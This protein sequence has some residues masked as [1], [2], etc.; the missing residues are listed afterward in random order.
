MEKQGII[1]SLDKFIEQA[2][3]LKTESGPKSNDFVKW[4]REV[5]Q[6]IEKN[7]GSDH[8]Q[9]RAFKKIDYYPKQFDILSSESSFKKAW[10]DGLA[11]AKGILEKLRTES[12]SSSD[13]QE[14]EPV[15]EIK[16][17]EEE[18]I[19]AIK[20]EEPAPPEPKEVK[21]EEI[22]LPEAQAEIEVE[23]QEPEI[24][25]IDSPKENNITA[26]NK[27][28]ARSAEKQEASPRG[29]KVLLVNISDEELNE[30]IFKFIKRMGYEPV[31][32]DQ[33][34]DGDVFSSDVLIS[35]MY[36]NPVF[37]II[38]WRAEMECSGRKLPKPHIIFGTGFYVAKLTHKRVLI[39]SYEDIDFNSEE[40]KG[41]NFLSIDNIQEL[42]ELKL[43][44][45]MDIAG[46]NIDFNFLKKK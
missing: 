3:V 17:A 10:L 39:I 27:K 32:V 2:D 28:E 12:L 18:K 21:V 26:K 33:N 20:K 44:R 37:A 38:H 42:M 31:V 8:A 11:V 25:I 29:Q 9:L 24:E 30:D 16:K 4:V 5:K 22:I 45:E 14:A 46:L 1:E 43:A 6:F 15:Q 40:F 35:S 34:T 23:E 7:F 36:G 41:L 13:S 19:V